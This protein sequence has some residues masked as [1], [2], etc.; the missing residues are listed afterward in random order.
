MVRYVAF[1]I[2]KVTPFS[3]RS[4]THISCSYREVAKNTDRDISRYFSQITH[5]VASLLYYTTNKK[6]NNFLL[7]F[8]LRRTTIRLSLKGCSNQRKD[9]AKQS[10]ERKREKDKDGI[11]FCANIDIA[12]RI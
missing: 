1:C 12:T 10:E 4:N 3:R 7:R 8:L 11:F 2:A 5:S 9:S 6:T